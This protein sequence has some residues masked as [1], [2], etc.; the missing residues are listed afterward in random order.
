MESSVRSKV[1]QIVTSIL[2]LPYTVAG[3]V[4]DPKPSGHPGLR[5]YPRRDLPVW[6]VGLR[7][8]GR[9]AGRILRDMWRLAGGDAMK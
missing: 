3:Y 4:V 2:L 7:P 5:G 9:R 8:P 1:M 6:R